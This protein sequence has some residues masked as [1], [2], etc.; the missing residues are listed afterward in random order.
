MILD[1][2]TFKYQ[3]RA[4]IEKVSITAPY[5]MKAFFQDQGCFLYFKESESGFNFLSSEENA[6]IEGNEAVL[7]RCGSYF[8]DL[9]QEVEQDKVEVYAVHLF[10]DILKKLYV[11][12][13]P[14]IIEKR[15]Y[16]TRN[17]II[18]PQ[19]I[20]SKFIDSLE[21]YFQNPSLV[22]DDLVELKIKEL[23]LLLIQTKNIESIL[24]LVMDLNSTRTIN[25]KKV[26]NT[27][28][29]SDLS[30][31]ELAKLSN[32]SL[33]SFKREFKKE[34]GDSPKNYIIRKRLDKAKELLSITHMSVSE[35]AYETGFND[36][37]YFTRLFKKHE[38]IAPTLFRSE[39]LE[40]S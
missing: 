7:L 28:L 11:D 40:M 20:I 5:R 26:I 37:L 33:S 25:L 9:L 15:A 32:L 10:P 36:P 13:L 35:I 34:F 29:Y 21:F 14:E 3:G 12:E 24:E 16:T 8:L 31:K 4:L 30:V 2:Q 38:G 27:H 1:T 22:S 17:Q 6:Q 39:K 23:I 18:A 19:D